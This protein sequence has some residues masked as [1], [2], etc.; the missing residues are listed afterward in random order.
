MIVIGNR[1]YLF[2]SSSHGITPHVGSCIRETAYEG[3]CPYRGMGIFYIR[4]HVNLNQQALKK[5]AG[6]GNVP[7]VDH[8]RDH[9]GTNDSRMSAFGLE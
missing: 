5:F 9:R 2:N 8:S 3:K 7:T 4:S 1:T 6:H